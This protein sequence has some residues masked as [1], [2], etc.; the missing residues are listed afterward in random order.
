MIA[1]ILYPWDWLFFFQFFRVN[2]QPQNWDFEGFS[3]SFWKVSG[4]SRLHFYTIIF[5]TLCKLLLDIWM[6][7]STEFYETAV[8]KIDFLNYLFFLICVLG[9]WPTA[10]KR[11]KNYLYSKSFS[12]AWPLCSS[13]VCR[14][15]NH[16]I[17]GKESICHSKT[18]WYVT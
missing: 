16:I 17:Q 12:P 3:H 9:F 11:H 2:T 13:E 7:F 1:S 4:H 18:T 14:Q 5:F 8:D 15:Q 6:S 10:S